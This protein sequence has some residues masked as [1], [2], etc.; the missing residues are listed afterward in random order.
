MA[1]PSLFS[2]TRCVIVRGLEGLP[3]DCDDGHPRL[4]RGAGR[5]HRP[6]AG[7][8]RRTEGQRA[9]DQAAQAG[10]GHR[11]E[12]GGDQG[13]RPAGLRHVG[14]RRPRRQ[15]RRRRGRLPR[16][17]GRGRPA[18]AGRRGPPADQRLPR[19]SSSP[20]R[21]CSATSAAGPRPSRSQ[22]PTR[23]S[24]GARR[25]RSRSCAGRWTAA[26][27]RCSSPRRWP[28]RPAASRA[29]SAPPT[30][31]ARA[32]WP[33]SSASRRGRS[34]RSATSPG[35]G[36]PRRSRPRAGRRRG[37]RRH[38]GPGPRRVVHARAAGAHRRRPAHRPLSGRRALS[39]RWSDRALP[40]RWKC[41]AGSSVSPTED[42]GRGLPAHRKCPVAAWER[43][44]SARSR[45]E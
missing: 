45:N 33:A 24:P 34:G 39:S 19:S 37:G 22:W 32:T 40:S 9:A 43:A 2:S 25:R 16:H 6:G 30:A 10:V 12:V 31:C 36:L 5:R 29:S 26:P 28:A 35:R 23:R 1:A 38:Q 42:P 4:R 27:P 20:S 8:R 18:L 17:R 21:R 7:A 13:L 11:G 44:G 3:D 41:R 14:V 15:D